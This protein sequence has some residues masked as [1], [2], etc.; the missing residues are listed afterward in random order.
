MSFTNIFTTV[1]FVSLLFII[2]HMCE[3]TYTNPL[4][5]NNPLEFPLLF[6]L[7]GNKRH[8]LGCTTPEPTECPI[9]SY[10]S[11]K[12][13]ECRKKWANSKWKWASYALLPSKGRALEVCSLKGV[14]HYCLIS[15][16]NSLGEGNEGQNVTLTTLCVQ[17]SA[18]QQLLLY[19]LWLLQINLSCYYFIQILFNCVLITIN[20]FKLY[21]LTIQS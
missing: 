17:H 7:T 13:S 20:F 14:G 15:L 16:W 2:D 11:I 18:L 4:W 8:H 21:L 5:L 1:F 3:V 10:I 6:S 19:G 9:R 12:Y